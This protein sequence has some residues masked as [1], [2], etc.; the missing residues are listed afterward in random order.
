MP[1]YV[2]GALNRRVR[3]PNQPLAV[4]ITA[5]AFRCVDPLRWVTSAFGVL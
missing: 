3:T 5:S 4:S 2:L 1:I